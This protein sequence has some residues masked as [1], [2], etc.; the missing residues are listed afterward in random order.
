MFSAAPAA[1]PSI[2]ARY[3]NALTT[4]EN[5]RDWWNTDFF[6]AKAANSF[7][8]RR[9]LRLR[10]RHEVSNNPFL[11]GIANNNADDLIG[12]GPTLQV[13]TPDAGYNRQVEKSFADWWDEVGGVEK[14]R[15]CKLAK[16]VD[17]EGFLVFK[18][19]NELDHPVKLY[20]LD[21]EADQVTTPMPNDMGELWLDGLILHPVTG[22]PTMYTILKQ[23][24]GDWYFNNM[25]PLAVDRIKSK[26]VVHWF[27]KFRPG[28]VR[29]VPVFTPSLD[30]FSELRAYR[31][32]VL[33]AAE[34]A[35]DYAAVLEQDR[36]I[37][38]VSDEDA[39]T[40]FEAF[41]KVEIVRK[42]MTMLPP[43]AK[44]SQ[45]DAKQPTTTYEMFQEK[46]LGEACRPLAYPLNLALGTSQKFNFSSAKLDHV[47]YRGQLTVERDDCNR[48][49]MSHIFRVWFDEAVLA[50]AVRSLD[51]AVPD[52]D[53]HWPGFQPLDPL[54]EAQADH[55]RISAGTLTL[56][57]FWATRGEDWPDVLD[58]LAKEKEEIE[59][60][61]L[62]F[63]QP[64]RF[65]VT[66]ATTPADDANTV[67]P[68]EAVNV[69]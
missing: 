69:P 40:E 22:R 67:D 68:S 8:V 3:D 56:K 38:V 21:I 43:G 7:Q 28:Q 37:G 52:H 65:T 46:C 54:V 60:L 61:G 41:K 44:L 35:A 42:M 39:D 32:A 26:W 12:C 30:L 1:K 58:Q 13:R 31:R 4:P 10:S 66:E 33:G 23:H 16:T 5:K 57:E 47:N 24:P 64:T 2:R 49:V 18:T 36:G 27:P 63:G 55:D 29:G 14:L 48:V 9:T 62:E 20:P 6:S 34:T 50:R 45:F 15:T 19:L 17:G 53:F 51:G 25:N 59:R 11:F